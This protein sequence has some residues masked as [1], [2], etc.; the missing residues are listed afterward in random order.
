MAVQAPQGAPGPL[1][2]AFIAAMDLWKGALQPWGW[3][4]W[5]LPILDD[6]Y[7]HR[8]DVRSASPQWV[9][10]LPVGPIL[11]AV[12]DLSP[13]DRE[14]L[15]VEQALL[16]AHFNWGVDPLPAPLGAR[17]H[18]RKYFSDIVDVHDPRTG[19]PG[20]AWPA[21]VP[22]TGPAARHTAFRH[23]FD[24][25]SGLAR[26]PQQYS[27][28]IP[29]YSKRMMNM[30]L[31]DMVHVYYADKVDLPKG[32]RGYDPGWG[33]GGPHFLGGPPKKPQKKARV[34]AAPDDPPGPPDAL[35]GDP[36]PPKP[37]GKQRGPQICSV[38]S[39]PRK[40]HTCTG[41]QQDGGSG[42]GGSGGGGQTPA[43]SASL[44]K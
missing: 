8:Q 5:L 12:V 36:A 32:W 29:M 10:W 6:F 25:A 41:P 34:G 44:Q 43:E 35:G 42:G 39:K 18:F 19:V 2:P 13:A 15:I 21:F 27:M 22:G 26:G 17:T 7:C 1:S 33:G 3:P 14:V 20:A 11:Q 38:C 40:G 4:A 30:A 31:E 9:S 23:L 16:S 28:P 24:V 37:T